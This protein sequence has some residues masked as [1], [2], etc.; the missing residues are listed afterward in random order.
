MEFYL[1]PGF[2]SMSPLSEVQGPVRDI[3]IPVFHHYRLPNLHTHIQSNTKLA[4]LHYFSPRTQSPISPVFISDKV[5]SVPKY[6]SIKLWYKRWWNTVSPFLIHP[7]N[8]PCNVPLCSQNEESP[9][10]CYSYQKKK[11]MITPASFLEQDIICSA[12][13]TWGHS[14]M[15]LELGPCCSRYLHY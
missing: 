11:T 8:V 5:V 13:W 1:K 10:R 2:I 15:N 14:F 7:A 9:K 12:F 3:I 4:C 6:N